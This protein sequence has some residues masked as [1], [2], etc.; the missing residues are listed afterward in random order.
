MVSLFSTLVSLI[1]SMGL[2]RPARSGVLAR[3]SHYKLG[4]DDMTLRHDISQFYA[5]KT[6]IQQLLG[7]RAWLDLKECTS[8]PT[9]RSYVLKLLEAV[10]ISTDQSIEIRDESWVAEVHENLQRGTI[11]AKS[12]KE[13]DELISVLTATLLRQ[14]FLQIGMLPN[15]SSAQKVTRA[16]EYWTLNGHRTVQ[17][18]QTPTQIES[19]FWSAQQRSIGLEKQMELRKE[20]RASK[21]KLPYSKWCRAREA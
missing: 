8:V 21:S 15:R 5:L 4:L 10:R 14:V 7:N 11:A 16:R 17:Y 13:I 20:H 9:W 2:W 3:Q 19:A 1:L 12:A 18:T 6:A